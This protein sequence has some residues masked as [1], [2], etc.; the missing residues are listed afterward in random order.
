MKKLKWLKSMKGPCRRNE[1]GDRGRGVVP[2][3]REEV[4][5]RVGAGV[6]AVLGAGVGP[7]WDPGWEVRWY[8]A[9]LR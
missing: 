1:K 7:G 2:W 9:K 6:R 4:G 3:V 5:D 8:R